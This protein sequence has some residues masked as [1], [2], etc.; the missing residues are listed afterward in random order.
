MPWTNLFGDLWP[1]LQPLATLACIMQLLLSFSHFCQLLACFSILLHLLATFWYKFRQF[2]ANFW[3]PLATFGSFSLSRS[4]LADFGHFWATFYNF[5]VNFSKFKHL[6]A[7]LINFWPFWHLL[8]FCS[9][10]FLVY[11]TPASP[12]S[13][14][15]GYQARVLADFSRPQQQDSPPY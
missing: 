14:M 2:W 12:P 10:H 1:L 8:A 7:T 3:H 5:F 4:L 6:F 13:C 9:G 11:Q 15:V